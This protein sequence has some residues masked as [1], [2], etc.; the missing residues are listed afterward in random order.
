M[1][2]AFKVPATACRAARFYMHI[3]SVLQSSAPSYVKVIDNKTEARMR[4]LF[5]CNSVK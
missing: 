4:A 1:D 2:L 5:V 3:Q